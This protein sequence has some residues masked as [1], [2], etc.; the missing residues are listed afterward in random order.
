[1]QPRWCIA[2]LAAMLC[3]AANAA[4][5]VNV[6]VPSFD[7]PFGQP[8]ML[9]SYWYPAAGTA[10]APAPALLLLHG[11]GGP[12]SNPRAGSKLLSQRM[13]EYAAMFNAAGIHVLVTDS[14][15]PRGEVELCT[16]RPEDR[17]MSQMQRRRDALGALSWLAAQTEVDAKRIG[18]VGWSHG[19]SAVLASTNLR[20]VEVQ[21]STARPSLAVAFYPGC[22]AEAR[23]GYEAVAPLL[24]LIGDADD[25]TPPGPCRDLARS[26]GGAGVELV[27]YPGAVHGF[28]GS[29]KVRLREDVPGGVNPGKGVHVGGDPAARAD[30]QARLMRFVKR[31]WKLP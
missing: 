11:C 13:R 23:R 9:P 3:G 20:H 27:G 25:W 4:P 17:S 24:L 15:T 5:P 19:G 28:D 6:A 1:M 30:A 21:V 18:I 26:A 7:Q 8:M 12:Y 31:R 16:T 10:K 2:L 22:S 29:G 14:L